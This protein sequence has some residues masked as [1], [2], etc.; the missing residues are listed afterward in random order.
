MVTAAVA[1]QAVLFGWTL[2]AWESHQRQERRERTA[3]AG[4]ARPAAVVPTRTAASSSLPDTP[5]GRVLRSVAEPVVRRDRYESS[6]Q[7]PIRR[8]R[9][10]RSNKDDKEEWKE[11]REKEKEKRKDRDKDREEDD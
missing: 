5:P 1:A 2:Q 11:R 3:P 10:H 6:P 4:V 8:R 7:P 9:D